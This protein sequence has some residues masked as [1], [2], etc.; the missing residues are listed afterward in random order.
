MKT[1]MYESQQGISRRTEKKTA[2][3]KRQGDQITPGVK[4]SHVY[5]TVHLSLSQSEKTGFQSIYYLWGN[6]AGE[7][8]R[9]KGEGYPERAH[10]NQER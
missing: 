10:E 8:V 6:K 5:P 1:R 7:T 2:T 3:R 9:E 4:R